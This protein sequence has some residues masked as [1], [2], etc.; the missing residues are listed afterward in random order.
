MSVVITSKHL[1]HEERK[2]RQ[3][4]ENKLKGKAD[5]LKLLT[6]LNSK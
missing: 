5:K 2:A 6:Y 1:K 3:D 4:Q